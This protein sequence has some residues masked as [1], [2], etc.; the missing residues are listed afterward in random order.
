MNRLR[1]LKYLTAFVLPALVLFS[2][3]NSGW[4][5]YSALLFA[6]V[7]L[8]LLEFVVG[9]DTSN[10]NALQR[11]IAS[12]DPLYDFIIYLAL[13]AQL[14]CLW[15]FLDLFSNGWPDAWTAGG[16]ITAMGLMCGVFGINI[17]HEL[18]H[19][20]KGYEKLMA[21]A[22]LSTSLYMH[23]YIE[24]NRG[25]H[26]NVGTPEDPASARK[27]EMIYAF[28]FRSVLG[29][30]LSA[31]A[32]VKKERQRKKRAV[33]SISNEFIQYM[34][35]QLLLC[36][37]IGWIWGIGAWCAFTLAAI[38]GILLLES[39]NYIEHYGLYRKKVSEFRYED[40]EPVHSWNSDF[41]LGRLVLF[42]L[43]R[44]SDHHWDPSKHYQTLDSMDHA[45]N[46]P[47][48]YPAMIVCAL[49]PPAWFAIMNGRLNP[50]PQ[51]P[52]SL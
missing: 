6:F 20:N 34:L 30:L 35:I 15:R 18:G 1:T 25:H 2:L 33:W 13:P 11:E 48:G 52:T 26:R 3:N 37:V 39:V 19:R 5:A 14:F 10:L 51:N 12:Q 23:F 32:I 17:A 9:K 21:K 47:A 27:G 49:F 4:L 29:S 31:W 42:E 41:V 7:L 44:H 22:L 45:S 16:W 28:Y 43:T 38:M 24:H 46:L 36:V 40:V 50:D 8:P